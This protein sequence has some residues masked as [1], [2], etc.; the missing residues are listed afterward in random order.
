MPEHNGG[1]IGN[2][3]HVEIRASVGERAFT[4]DGV[5]YELQETA[6]GL[7]WVLIGEGYECWMGTE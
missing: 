3:E 4:S 7:W 5:V 1:V 6:E 2:G